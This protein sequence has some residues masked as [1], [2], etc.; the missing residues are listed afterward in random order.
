MKSR[1]AVLVI[2][3]ALWLPFQALA[4]ALLQCE[5]IASAASDQP[6]AEEDCH[7]PVSQ[8]GAQHDLEQH[9][10]HD[11]SHCYHCNGG[12]HG[13]QSLILFDQR[14]TSIAPIV[15][16]PSNHAPALPANYRDTPDRPPRSNS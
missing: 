6:A 7:G 15:Q 2:L 14:E 10:Q 16:Q 5:Q 11:H 3:L 13:L 1:S 9:E 4:G 12:C 8:S